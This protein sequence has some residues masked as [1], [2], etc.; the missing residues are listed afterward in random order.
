MLKIK[1]SINYGDLHQNLFR[2]QISNEWNIFFGAY[3]DKCHTF[4]VVAK[5]TEGTFI[6]ISSHHPSFLCH[7]FSLSPSYSSRQILAQVRGTATFAFFPRTIPPGHSHSL[8]K[9]H[10]Y[11]YNTAHLLLLLLLSSLS[12][13]SL[14]TTYPW[15]Q[16]T[17][18]FS[19]RFMRS[20]S[21]STSGQRRLFSLA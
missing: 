2:Y 18:E 11:T 5:S 19:T 13:L 20:L 17:M 4:F 10:P 9:S 8:F 12:T 15:N 6:P 1:R 16:A 3:R 21:W 14:S 7:T